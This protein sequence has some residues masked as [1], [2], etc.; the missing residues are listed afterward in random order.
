MISTDRRQPTPGS[1]ALD[2]T[3]RFYTRPEHS[4]P[5][6]PMAAPIATYSRL[7]LLLRSPRHSLRSLGWGHGVPQF[8]G[9]AS[10]SLRLSPPRNAR[11]GLLS[12]APLHERCDSFFPFNRDCAHRHSRFSHAAL[13][14]RVVTSATA[15][16]GD[17]HWSWMTSVFPAH[18]HTP[19]APP[20]QPNGRTHTCASIAASM[21]LRALAYHYLR[22]ATRPAT[23]AL[24]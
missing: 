19:A 7:G 23:T 11:Y 15:L 21:R 22:P 9:T 16:C 3:L 18:G 1:L 8:P 6:D 24:L 12:L 4:L 14:R 5:V 2:A 20:R 10:T 13:P 17:N